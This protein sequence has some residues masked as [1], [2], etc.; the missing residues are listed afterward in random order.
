[1]FIN[2]KAAKRPLRLNQ[3]SI[4]NVM[5]AWEAPDFVKLPVQGRSRRLWAK[6]SCFANSHCSLTYMANISKALCLLL[7]LHSYLK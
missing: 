6:F 5:A 4:S 7:A 3:K 2:V 1:M